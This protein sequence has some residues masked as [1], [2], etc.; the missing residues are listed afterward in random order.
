MTV[1]HSQGNKSE[2][3]CRWRGG[4]LV[5]VIDFMQQGP[6]IFFVL[7]FWCKWVCKCKQTMEEGEEVRLSLVL[8]PFAAMRRFEDMDCYTPLVLVILELYAI[9]AISYTKWPFTL[10]YDQYGPCLETAICITLRGVYY[11]LVK[12]YTRPT[13]RSVRE[14]CTT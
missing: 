13:L 5:H 11:M 9:G 8:W 2:V 14:P 1:T 10:G 12:Q 7:F 6:L 4:Q 3:T